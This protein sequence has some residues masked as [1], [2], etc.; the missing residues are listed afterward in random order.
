MA[1]NGAKLDLVCPF[2]FT[3]EKGEFFAQGDPLVDAKGKNFYLCLLGTDSD[4]YR[5][6]IKRRFEK[7]QKQKNQKIDLDDAQLKA[8]Q[9]LAKCTTECY[10]LENNKSVECTRDNLT[11]LYLNLPWL[12]EQA[13]TFMGDRSNLSTS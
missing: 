6:A 10:M 12:R 11:R 1:N 5:N 2:D 13:E 4:V 3:D 9:L 8:A 7:N